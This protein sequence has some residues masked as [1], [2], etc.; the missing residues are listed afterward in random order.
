MNGQNK[1]A[2]LAFTIAAGF[3]AVVSLSS[4]SGE[5][6]GPRFTLRLVPGSEYKFMSRWFIFPVPIYPQAACWL[7]TLQGEYVDTLYATAKGAKGAWVSAPAG[8]RPEALPVW[9][10]LRKERKPK[11]DGISG[12]TPSG[13]TKRE[14]G[15][16][17][18]LPPGKYKVM[19]E[20][21]RSYDYNERYTRE[22][23]GVTG[24]PSL[25]YEC[26]IEVGSGP[27]KAVFEPIGT[28]SLD[29]SDGIVHP[30][31]EGIT[32]ALKLFESAE[33]TYDEGVAE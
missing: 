11:A 24:Q 32:T 4:L 30:G 3:L 23:S 18:T 29:G 31:L 13:A 7:E 17:G 25:V 5:K 12:A 28:G 10:A 1:R 20:V 6:A 27:A 2:R 8:G 19:L 16:A 15:L 26:E 22:N 21:N 9:F 14:S 33:I